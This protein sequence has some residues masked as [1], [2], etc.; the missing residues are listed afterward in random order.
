MELPVRA[1]ST[2][3]GSLRFWYGASIE[4]FLATEPRAIVGD[5]SRHSGFAV[6]PTHT[7][8]WLIEIDIL[9]TE[10]RGL[11]GSIFFEFNIPRMGR[12]IDVVLILR[13]VVFAI[14][15]KVGEKTFDRAAI[16]P[17]GV[18]HPAAAR[19][20]DTGWRAHRIV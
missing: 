11:T 7:G 8:A 15:F 16:D 4:E 9:Q 2:K 10:L 18:R 1:P 17:G 19:P 14:E 5:L 12:R 3:A 6:L 13:R 20:G